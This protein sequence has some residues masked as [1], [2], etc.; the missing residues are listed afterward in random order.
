MVVATGGLA[1]FASVAASWRAAALLV[2]LL[3]ATFFAIGAVGVDFGS[4]WDEWY[5]TDGVSDCIARL[6]LYP[7]GVSYGGPYFT[8]G[9][10]V[11]LAHEWRHLVQLVPDL[12]THSQRM[13]P[14]GYPSMVQ[15]KAS[16][17]SLVASGSYVLQVR[18]VFLGMS[19]L[20]PLWMFLAARRAWPRRIGAALGAAAFIAL[21][22]ELGYHARWIAVDALLVQVAALELFLFVGVWR[23]ASSGRAVR[24]YCATAAA[25]GAVFACKLTGVFGVLP[26]ILTALVLPAPWR[27]SRRLALLVLG[28]GCYLVTA[29]VLSPQVFLEPVKVLFALRGGSADY[30]DVSPADAYYVTPAAHLGR[31]LVWLA[32][33][34]PSPFRGV[35]FGFSVVGLIGLGA[36]LRR[37]RDR[38][39]TLVWLSFPV[40]LIAVFSRNHLLIVRQY[41]M[42]M[43]VLAF[44]FARG[45]MVTWDFLR[46]RRPLLGAVFTAAVVGGMLANVTFEA[47]R[48]RDVTRDSLQF[49]NAAAAADLLR[50]RQP[51]RMSQMVFDRLRP[52]LGAFYACRPAQPT[53]QRIDHVLAAWPEYAWRSNRLGFFH[54]SYGSA[55]VNLDYY[56]TWAGQSLGYRLLDVSRERVSTLVPSPTKSADLDCFPTGKTPGNDVGG[57]GG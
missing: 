26:V 1:R 40:S 37:P 2:L 51:V 46:P 17:L 56:A 48:A 19:S 42:C 9:F 14:A 18:Q 28:G 31:V 44:F 16:A 39:M 32:G 53:D 29:F 54:H 11:V 30:G 47:E 57:H 21:S 7:K 22:W 33:A 43:P 4:H 5:H 36:L 55:E 12:R 49:V 50:S 52:R 35:A 24:W 27:L 23:A 25:A 38:R 41:L 34:V 20:A 6:S 8:L 15:F 13:D 10:P 3:I 45:L